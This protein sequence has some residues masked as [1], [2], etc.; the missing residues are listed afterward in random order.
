MISAANAA[1]TGTR[2]AEQL[3]AGSAGEFGQVRR[4]V[5]VIAIRG[6]IDATVG[7]FD[8]RPST[9]IAADAWEVAQTF[10]RCARPSVEP[11]TQT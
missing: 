8:R 11:P 7:Q 9:D 2:V 6:A 5:R 1:S 4:G 3:C 10:D